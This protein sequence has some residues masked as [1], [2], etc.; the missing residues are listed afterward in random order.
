MTEIPTLFDL[1][2]RKICKDYHLRLPL[3]YSNVVESF[4][5]NK[6]FKI[7]QLFK[8]RFNLSS[9]ILKPTSSKTYY[10]LSQV[11]LHKISTISKAGISTP[12]SLKR[13]PSK[14]FHKKPSPFRSP[15]ISTS[16][17]NSRNINSKPFISPMLRK[18]S[19]S[20]SNQ[21]DVI[22]LRNKVSSLEN[23]RQK[24]NLYFKY[25]TT[26]S[27]ET[28]NI[29]IQKWKMAAIESL[30][31]LQKIIGLVKP[32]I[33]IYTE[34]HSMRLIKLDEIAKDLKIDLKILGNYNPEDDE[35]VSV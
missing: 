6:A 11:D 14:A 29:L 20:P 33:G 10:C 23:E 24:Y 4:G 12:S 5:E 35:F 34:S 15:L 8:K 25:S 16:K 28:M 30:L 18:K 3:S 22:M 17:N 21:D 31:Y 32:S 9:T 26:N 19:I 2:A 27:S 7:M 1:C 13:K